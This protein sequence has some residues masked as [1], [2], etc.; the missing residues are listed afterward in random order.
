VHGV[1]QKG[2]YG[3]M[4]LILATAPDGVVVSFYYQKIS[5]PE[6]KRFRD[7]SFT[8][9]FKGLTLTDFYRYRHLPEV[10]RVNSRVGKIEDPTEKSAEDFAATLRGVMKNLILLD[11]FQLD[12]RYHSLFQEEQAKQKSEEKT[13]EKTNEEI[14]EET[15]E[16]PDS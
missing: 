14:D 2:K 16:K 5:S 7:P 10:E 11:E 3:G 12:K 13:D 1:N 6:A 4:Q 8:D 9:Q 15:E